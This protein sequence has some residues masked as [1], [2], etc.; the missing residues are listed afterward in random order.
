[1]NLWPAASIAITAWL[2]L[3]ATVPIGV[4]AHHIHT[5]R[6]WTNRWDKRLKRHRT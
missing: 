6:S 4:L 3:A 2:S 5:R 1:M